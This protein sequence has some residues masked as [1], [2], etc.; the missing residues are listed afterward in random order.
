MTDEAYVFNET[1]KERAIVRRSARYKKGGSKSKS[2][3]LG[4]DGMSRKEIEAMH[5]E[6][7]SWK[8]TD[9][10]T[11][12]EFKEM[13]HDIQIEYLNYTIDTYGIGLASISSVLFEKNSASLF[14][15]CAYHKLDNKIHKGNAGG[16]TKKN[17]AAFKAIVLE[18]RNKAMPTPESEN[19]VELVEENLYLTEDDISR[20]C[21]MNFSTVYT[22]KNIDFDEL[23]R[24]EKM[25]KG[26]KIRVSISISVV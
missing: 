26:Q 13:P 24:V 17:T 18:N 11:W 10:Y 23:A 6:V 1:N 25:F 21:S 3:K 4:C 12:N 7:K 19:L 16:A 8:L 9:F 20:R 5:G 22:S 14:K 2:C 15:Y